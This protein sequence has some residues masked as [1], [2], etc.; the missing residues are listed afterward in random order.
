M[1]FGRHFDCVVIKAMTDCEKRSKR[2]L[3]STARSVK[4]DWLHT[5]QISAQLS[6]GDVTVNSLSRYAARLQYCTVF[7]GIGIDGIIC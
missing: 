3:H 5:Q 7:D 1:L 2:L 4:V 6:T